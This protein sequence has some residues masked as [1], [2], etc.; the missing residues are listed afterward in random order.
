[1][2]G[3]GNVHWLQKMPKIISLLAIL[4]LT[5]KP[6]LLISRHENFMQRISELWRIE[7]RTNGHEEIIINP[8]TKEH[9]RDILGIS[10]QGSEKSSPILS[11]F[12]RIT[13]LLL[14]LV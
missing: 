2:Y 3:D 8:C 11:V 14:M 4:T 5:V 12:V 7:T 1:M 13:Q 10:G 9:L 6:N